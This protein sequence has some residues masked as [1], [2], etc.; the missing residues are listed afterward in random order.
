MSTDSLWSTIPTP[1]P[2]TYL[3]SPSKEQDWHLFIRLEFFTGVK[4]LVMMEIN[5]RLY[6]STFSCNSIEVLVTIK[7]FMQTTVPFRKKYLPLSCHFSESLSGEKKSFPLSFF[8]RH[9]GMKIFP[10]ETYQCIPKADKD[11]KWSENPSLNDKTLSL[12]QKVLF[13]SGEMSKNR[14]IPGS[15]CGFSFL[16]LFQIAWT[17]SC[18]S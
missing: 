9:I 15:I 8:P 3:P 17:L 6:L 12:S 11:H 10:A 5:L 4:C 18:S 16:H 2:N 14:S 7:V 1:S 13:P